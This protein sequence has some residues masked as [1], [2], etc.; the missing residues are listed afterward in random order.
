M[1]YP[2]GKLTISRWIDQFPFYLVVR[3][4]KALPQVDALRQWFEMFKEGGR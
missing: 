4:L 3:E 1:S 2:N